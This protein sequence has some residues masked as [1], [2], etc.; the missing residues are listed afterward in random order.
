MRPL[1]AALAALLGGTAWALG[2]PDYA[3]LHARLLAGETAADLEDAL[4]GL[5]RNLE[6]ARRVSAAE[7]TDSV[8]RDEL[9]GGDILPPQVLAGLGI[10]P[11]VSSG[12]AHVPAGVMHTYGYLFSQLKTAYG[13]K[14]RRWTQS[15][16]DERLGLAP[17]MFSPRPPRGEFTANVTK[18]LRSLIR[19][20]RGGR[21]EEAV[22][23]RTPEGREV[24]GTVFTH[25]F[26][27]KPLPGLEAETHLLVYELQMKGRRRLVTAFPVSA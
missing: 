27:L 10:P 8:V 1:A 15:R 2:V 17:G 26:P 9:A 20:G 11:T 25:L 23:W 3:A 7:W 22:L 13:L 21:L 5:A 12:V 4:P 18:A 6:A 16:L 14:G 24:G 19:K